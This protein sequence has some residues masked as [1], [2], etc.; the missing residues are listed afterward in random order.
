MVRTGSHRATG[1]GPEPSRYR[2]RRCPSG[3]GCA[4][5]SIQAEGL[6]RLV[7]DLVLRVADTSDLVTALGR[8]PAAAVPRG[9]SAVGMTSLVIGH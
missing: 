4:R 1:S 7:V 6:E 9:Q 5:V 8:R 2:V 3:R